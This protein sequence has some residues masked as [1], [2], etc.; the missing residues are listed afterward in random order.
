MAPPCISP[1]NNALIDALSEIKS[2]LN[3]RTEINPSITDEGVVDIITFCY[4]PQFLDLP[5]SGFRLFRSQEIVL[6][7]I[8][9]GTVGN[10]TLSISQEDWEWLDVNSQYGDNR[11]SIEKLRRREQT[12]NDP[13]ARFTELTLVLG[14]RSGK[15]MMSSIIAAYEAYKL[16]VIG[17]G[18]P[19]TYYG[20]PRNKQI[21]ILN[22]A[23]SQEQAGELF[24]E[25]K[26]RIGHSPFFAG[27]I[28]HDTESL[29]RLFTDRDLKQ[30]AD[31]SMNVRLQGS[32]VIKCGHRNPKSLRGKAAIC[33]IFDEL[34]FYDE[35]KKVSGIDF[36]NSLKPSVSQ[37]DKKN[38]G[39]LVEI[40]SPG[41]RSG[42]F[43]KRAEAGLDPASSTMLFRMPTWIFNPEMPESNKFLKEDRERS[44]E[45]YQIEYGAEWPEGGA[46]SN[47]F[48][49]VLIDR[50]LEMG[51]AHGC[52][53][54][55][56]PRYNS[57]Y[58]AHIDPAISG[59]N[60]AIVIIRKEMYRDKTGAIC[61]RAILAKVKVWRPQK[62]IGHDLLQI[63]N[64]IV[65]L[66]QKFHVSSLSYDRFPSVS[67]L[68]VLR[69]NGINTI[70]TTFN[71][72]YKNKIY[73]NLRDLMCKEE[74]GLYL[75]PF[76]QLIS[77]LKNLQQKPLEHSV[78]IGPEKRGEVPWDDAADCLAGATFMICG[79]H[80][81]RWPGVV[82]TYTALR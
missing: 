39:M 61:P 55:V 57:E 29:I 42:I 59:D 79:N 69:R 63:E 7:A 62:G 1:V 35:G 43:Y 34:A 13:Q 53:E 56:A 52:M 48:P 17:G 37:F 65:Q 9:M 75:Y 44:P 41:P 80:Y 3:I 77:E 66:C 82:M 60:Y 14:R 74:G 6:K 51:G 46:S 73:Q 33:V 54:E 72:G 23:T 58:Y 47:Y 5:G 12:R 70:Q 32:V 25:I 16:L 38:A 27:R 19:H 40:S 15:T 81:Q 8:Y 21:Y 78:W 20:V 71:R 76:A 28:E 18:D 2:S 67:T 68:A 64:E 26:S 22:V 10:K 45:M 31:E 50:A 36:Y 49:E 4:D 30:R 24:N 11:V